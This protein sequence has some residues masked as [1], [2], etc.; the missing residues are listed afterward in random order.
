MA[1]VLEMVTSNMKVWEK[2]LTSAIE[3]KSSKELL[4]L[5]GIGAGSIS[6]LTGVYF[7]SQIVFPKKGDPSLVRPERELLHDKF[8][9]AKVPENVDV[10]VIGSGMGG[11][12]CAAILSRLGK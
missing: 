11:L 5:A 9:P 8:T 7:F 3:K 10:I 1:H 6:F 4:L 2:H 12:T